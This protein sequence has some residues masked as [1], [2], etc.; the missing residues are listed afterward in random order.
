MNHR[1]HQ[2]LKNSFLDSTKLKQQQKKKIVSFQEME[3][4]NFP[5]RH[6]RLHSSS[7]QEHCCCWHTFAVPTIYPTRKKLHEIHSNQELI[8]SILHFVVAVACSVEIELHHYDYYYHY[9]DSDFH[10][11][12]HHQIHHRCLFS[13]ARTKD[14]HRSRV[15]AA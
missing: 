3:D 8:F 15:A 12:R 6:R 11:H 10:L 7:F 14:R 9:Y 4:L 1:H 5:R 13:R 2:F